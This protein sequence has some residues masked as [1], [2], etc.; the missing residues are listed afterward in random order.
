MEANET[1]VLDKVARELQYKGTTGT[2]L[3]AR[4]RTLASTMG[5]DLVS[6]M[7]QPDRMAP[8]I[9][10][11]FKCPHTA[12]QHVGAVVSALKLAS[13]YFR[14]TPELIQKWQH[15]H[16]ETGAAS[17]RLKQ[18]I[19]Q[20]FE[21]ADGVSETTRKSCTSGL[22][23]M[24]VIVG[25]CSILEV[26][27]S[28][29]KYLAELEL[30]CSSSQSSRGTYIG[31][32]LSVYKH[33]PRLSTAHADAHAMWRNEG[34]AL[35]LKQKQAAKLN[36]PSNQRQVQHYTPMHEWKAAQQ[37]L[38]ADRDPHSSQQKSLALVLLTYA[39]SMPPKRA[40]LGAVQVFQAQ[41]SSDK[42]LIAAPNRLIVDQAILFLGKHKTSKHEMHA[43]GVTESLSSEFM[44]VLRDSL[45]RYPRSH[46]FVDSNGRP[47]TNQGFSK[48]VIRCTKRIFGDKAPGVSLLRHAFATELDF[49]SLTGVQKEDIALRM[50]HTTATQ[51][52]YRWH[53][54]A[55]IVQRSRA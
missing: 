20:L 31:R 14:Q 11:R 10:L 1:A 40:E 55:E 41:P 43:A 50:G 54:H 33:N 45:A 15:A 52:S 49:N 29:Q 2:T 19:S 6:I 7:R 36:A 12:H 21:H 32:I 24:M 51:D 18:S 53:G 22:L 34:Q 30:K 44:S 16:A 17:D 8:E 9:R 37:A 35:R 26:V 39:V 4:L 47:F 13:S 3:T 23:D 48:F 27:T 46:L 42:E 38:L 28:P 25:A 5:Q